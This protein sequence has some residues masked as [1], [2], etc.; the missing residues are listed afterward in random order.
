[1][2]REYINYEIS[3][4]LAIVTIDHPPMNTLDVATKEEIVVWI[5]E[6]IDFTQFKNPMQAIGPTMKHF[7]K[8]ADG[9]F[10]KEILQDFNKS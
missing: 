3:N 8:L 5:K 9:Q 2:G 4:Q 10:V 7:G 1:M 6:N